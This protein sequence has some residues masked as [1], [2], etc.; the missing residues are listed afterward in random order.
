M[1]YHPFEDIYILLTTYYLLLTTYYLLLTT[2]YLLLILLHYIP[3][4]KGFVNQH[5]KS[6]LLLYK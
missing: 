5:H 3:L 4:V 1:P 6:N 2:Y